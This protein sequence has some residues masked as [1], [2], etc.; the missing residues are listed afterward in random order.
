[1]SR[2]PGLRCTDAGTCLSLSLFLAV[3]FGPI[4]A[5]LGMTLLYCAGD[6]AGAASLL[7]PAGRRLDLLV[8]SVALAGTVAVS[9]TGIGALAGSLLWEIRSG[10]LSRLRWLVAVLVPVPAFLY[11]QAWMTLSAWL[12]VPGTIPEWLLSY[13]VQLGAFLPLGILL[14]MLAMASVDTASIE[15]ARLI[16][17]DIRVFRQIILPIA[18]PALGAS[19]G[20]IFLLGITDYSIPSLFSMNVY[21]LE[22]FSEFS[23]SNEPARALLIAAPLLAVTMVAL[24][25]SGGRMRNLMMGTSLFQRRPEPPVYPG[26]FVSMQYAALGLLL[27]H[28]LVLTGMLVLNAAAMHAPAEPVLAAGADIL[29]T[30]LIALAAALASLP[31][32]YSVATGMNRPGRM[33]RIW[34]FL[35]IAPLAIPAPLVG[36]GLIAVWNNPPIAWLYGTL[37]MPILAA[38]ARFTP[39][40]ALIMLAQLRH[41]DPLLTDAARVFQQSRVES[42]V[43]IRLPLLA[44]GLLASACVTF[45]LAAGELGATLLVI[46]PGLETVTI[47]IY[48]YL[49]YGS[50]SAVAE[51]GLVMMALMLLVGGIAVAV[52]RGWS[53]LTSG[54]PAG[55]G[56]C[57]RV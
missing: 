33:G 8:S 30:F 5:L 23:A 41:S 22:I 4:C 31:L 51:L 15:A 18:A 38:M 39:I 29:T 25:L 3:V 17:P 6:A 48:N 34:W 42:W 26:W 13:W 7:L 19:G 56:L 53:H 20:L 14:G 21:A 40:A 35:C 10:L 49:H 9:A 52:I 45:A 36:I 28:S 1:M 47:R 37:A 27:L 12:H 57:D 46:P 54:S 55:G 24:S 32:A 16:H 11:A 43:R 44:P 2:I 50:S